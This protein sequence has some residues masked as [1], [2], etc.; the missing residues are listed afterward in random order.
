[1]AR[2]RLSLLGSPSVTHADAAP[3]FPTRKALA[4]LV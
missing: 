3:A 1:M 4:L 2:L